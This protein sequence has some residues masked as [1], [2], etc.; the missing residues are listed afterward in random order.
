[1]GG[2]IQPPFL[3]TFM[4]KFGAFLMNPFDILFLMGIAIIV[5]YLNLFD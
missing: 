2:Q 1:V 4:G 3:H 5:N